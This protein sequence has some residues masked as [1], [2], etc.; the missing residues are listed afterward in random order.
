MFSP[1]FLRSADIFV[2]YLLTILSRLLFPH[3]ILMGLKKTRAVLIVAII[4]VILNITLSFWLVN[5]YGTVGVALGTIIAYFVAKVILVIY[6]YFR[7][8]I[9]PVEYIPVKWY[10][11]YSIA[12]GTVFILL[13]HKIIDI[14]L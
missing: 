9:S 6:N 3:T 8:G 13:D 14:G 2:V 4:E 5:H 7:M 1:D 12:L 11:I 10:I